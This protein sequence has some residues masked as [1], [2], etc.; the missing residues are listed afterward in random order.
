MQSLSQNRT[1]NRFILL[2]LIVAFMIIASWQ[3]APAYHSGLSF[4]NLDLFA[5]DASSRTN[6]SMDTQS[7]RLQ[8]QLRSH[9]D[10]WQAYSQLG[11][12][13]LQQARETGDPAYYQKTE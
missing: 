3:F 13:Y 8:D 5:S 12:A 2:G 9:P 6:A 11:L 1:L 4:T 10:D 7:Q